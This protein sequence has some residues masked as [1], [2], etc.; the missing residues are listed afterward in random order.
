[1]AGEVARPLTRTTGPPRSWPSTLNCTV[2]VGGAVV[3][4]VVPTVAVNVSG[5]PVFDGFAED[6]TVTVVVS[7]ACGVAGTMVVPGVGAAHMG[8]LTVL[9]SSVT[10]PLRASSRPITEAPVWAVMEVSAMIVP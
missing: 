2:P 9:L 6:V 8:R 1:M 5:A 10:A 7:P 4:D 3:W